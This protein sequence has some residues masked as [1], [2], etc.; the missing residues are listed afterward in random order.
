MTK[1]EMEYKAKVVAL[2]CVV[3]RNLGY[4]PSEDEIQ[5]GTIYFDGEE[6]ILPCT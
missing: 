3:C 1:A 4:G 6:E 5:N 2:G